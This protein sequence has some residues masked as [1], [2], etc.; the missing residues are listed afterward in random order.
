MRKVRSLSAFIFL[1]LATLPSFASGGETAGVMAF[2]ERVFHPLKWGMSVD[3]YKNAY[4]R[5][6][7]VIKAMSTG[8]SKKYF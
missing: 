6:D 8:Y 2:K 5:A 1:I 3:L 7:E 4:P